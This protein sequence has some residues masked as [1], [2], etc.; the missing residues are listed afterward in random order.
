MTPGLTADDLVIP[1]GFTPRWA[2]PGQRPWKCSVIARC[3][4]MAA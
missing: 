3:G 4:L 1:S 2:P